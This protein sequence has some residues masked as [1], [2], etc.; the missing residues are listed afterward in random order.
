MA[1]SQRKRA[2]RKVRTALALPPGFKSLS[3]AR[4]IRY[5]Q[6][7]WDRIADRASRVPV[8]KSHL[9]LAKERLD[10]YR[11]DS[12][13]RKYVIRAVVF[14][15]GEW[16]C[17]RCLEYDFVV[18]AKTLQQLSRALQLFIVGHIAVRLRHKQR[19]FHD[20]RRAPEKYWAMFRRSRLKLPAPMFKLRMLKSHGI[21]VAPPQISV[22]AP[23]AAA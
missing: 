17:A 11:R 16:L 19:P 1:S 4:Q 8:P 7:R 2:R 23:T 22:A 20:L 18:Q 13:T 14:Q 5:L 12:G 21:V 15:E 10:E 6:A 3:K 9:R